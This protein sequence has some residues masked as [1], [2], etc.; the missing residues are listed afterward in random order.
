[1]KKILFTDLDQT[2]LKSDKTV[3]RENRQAIQRMLDAGHHLVVATGRPVSSGLSVVRQLGLTMPGCYMIS[4]NGAVI[5][6]CAADI[7]L[8]KRT[9]PLEYVE[10]LFEEAE[11]CGLHIQ[12]YSDE[13]ILAQRNDRELEYY[14]QTTKM[15]YKIMKNMFFAMEKE[16]CKVLL[17]SLDEPEKLKRFQR[18]HRSWEEGKCSSFFSCREYL[19]YCPV[20]TDKGRGV[21]FLKE[22][23]NV[24]TEYT[25]AAGDERN[26]IPML[27]EAGTGIAVRNAFEEV[28]MAADFITANDNEHDAV[29]EIIDKFIL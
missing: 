15:P 19:E 8:D 3:S 20:D 27:R 26:D 17:A 14:V 11:R 13:Y 18:Q 12:T 10:Y 23:L 28:K 25:Y 29:A 22:F 6:D 7:I 1:M 9:L 2:L 24:A 16:P 4:F 5:Y 21:R